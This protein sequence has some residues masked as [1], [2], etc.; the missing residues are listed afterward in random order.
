MSKRDRIPSAADRRAASASPV[1][2]TRRVAAA[3]SGAIALVC[4]TS[5]A[6]AQPQA[7]FPTITQPTAT[8][9]AIPVE[10]AVTLQDGAVA[11]RPPEARLPADTIVRLQIVNLTDHAAAIIAPGFFGGGERIASVVQAQYAPGAPAIVVAPG[12]IGQ[13][14]VEVGAAGV[15]RMVCDVAAPG[16]RPGEAR[17]AII[18]EGMQEPPG[19][20]GQQVMQ[21]QQMPQQGQAGQAPGGQGGDMQMPLFPAPG[22]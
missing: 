6:G 15:Y 22:G 11:C 4:M 14:V 18:G 20:Q 10:V 17:I 2:G 8:H 13:V 12:T 5:V 19:E 1:I 7:G 21:G 16:A 3:L 9:Q